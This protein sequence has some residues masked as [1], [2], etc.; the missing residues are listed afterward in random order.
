MTPSSRQPLLEA[1]LRAF[2][3]L[4]SN[5]VSTLRTIFNRRTRDWHTDAASEVQLP[6]SADITEK[7]PQPSQPSFSGKRD[8]SAE[9]R[10]AQAE[11]RIPGIPVASS[12]GTTTYSPEAHNQDARH[13]AE[14]DTVVVAAL[15]RES[16]SESKGHAFP[17][18]CLPKLEERRQKAGVQSARKARSPL[19]HPLL[20]FR[21]KAL[22]AADPEP[23]GQVHSFSSRKPY[24]GY[25]GSITHPRGSMNGSPLSLRSAGMT[26]A[27]A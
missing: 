14:H 7:E 15:R 16:R 11:A 13:K 24:G 18:T 8:V 20:S 23:K 6:T 4:V 17:A 9:A 3:W 1:M 5:V 2:A 22:C 25:P 10:R 27:S 19:T 26:T 12:R 21:A